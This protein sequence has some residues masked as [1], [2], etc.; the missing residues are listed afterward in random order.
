M[1][2]CLH[3]NISEIGISILI[4]TSFLEVNVLYLMKYGCLIINRPKVQKIH[5]KY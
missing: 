1:L 4:S 3:P 2:I 5:L